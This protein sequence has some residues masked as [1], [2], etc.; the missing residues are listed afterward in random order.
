[1][2]VWRILVVRWVSSIFPE[3]KMFPQKDM[4]YLL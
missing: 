1:M 3:F 4:G 2:F